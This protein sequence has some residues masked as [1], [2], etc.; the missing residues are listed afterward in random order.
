MLVMIPVRYWQPFTCPG[1]VLP[2][3]AQ[4]PWLEYC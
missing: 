2:P 1:F 3:Q 4:V